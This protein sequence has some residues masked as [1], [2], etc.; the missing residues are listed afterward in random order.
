MSINF[1]GRAE[2]GDLEFQVRAVPH[3][4]ST[5]QGVPTP[6]LLHTRLV[7]NEE[8]RENLSAWKDSM[9]AEYQS[10]IAKGAIE[11]VSEEQVQSW[12]SSGEDIEVLPGRGVA[13]E[14]PQEGSPQK[15]YRAVICGNYQAP[16]PDRAKETL[17]AGGAD[18]VS[19]PTCLRWAGL[20][21]AGASTVDVKTAFL[22]AP[23]DASESNYLIC[24]PPRHVVLAG[25]VPPRT[26]WRVQG[27]LYGLLTS[28]RAWSKERDG[29]MRKFRWHCLGAGRRLLQCVTDPNVWR[30]TMIKC[31]VW[32][33]ATWMIS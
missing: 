2:H 26:R 14:K 16:H 23:V 20:R 1:K 30:L 4:L 5:D 19:L 6:G 21:A 3:V 10:L 13:S 12:I 28:P 11:P 32:S 24:N 15:K 8:V 27:A 9:Q 29:R 33:H 18:S 31:W 25:I 7:S 17:Y 22:N